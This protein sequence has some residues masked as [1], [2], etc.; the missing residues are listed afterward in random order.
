M[1]VETNYSATA[2]TEQLAER[3]ADIPWITRVT[4]TKRDDATHQIITERTLLRE[5]HEIHTIE[6]LGVTRTAIS[7][8]GHY[9]CRVYVKK[10]S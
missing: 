2:S 10:H 7:Q 6:N 1:S 8:A 3:F 9:G 5:N 4:E